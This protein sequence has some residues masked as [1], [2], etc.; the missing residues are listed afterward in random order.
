MQPWWLRFIQAKGLD[1]YAG[2]DA[3]EVRQGQAPRSLQPVI[4]MR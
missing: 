4:V 1:D 3:S 2:N